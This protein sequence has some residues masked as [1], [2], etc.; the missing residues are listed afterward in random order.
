MQK[1]LQKIKNHITQKDLR[2]LRSLY[3]DVP[4][5]D[6]AHI[7]Q[8]LEKNHRLLFFRSLPRSTA[9]Q[10]FAH[11]EHDEENILITELTDTETR[12][13][14]H[15]LDPDDRT[16]FFE[17]LPGRVTQ[18]I[19]NLL[20]DENIAE[21]RMLLGYPEDTIGR[22]MTPDYI[23]VRPS[24]TIYQATEHVRQWGNKSETS[25][26]IYV[27]NTA[28]ELLGAVSLRNLVIANPDSTVEM[29]MKKP[30]IA[31]NANADQESAV[32]MM[33]KYDVGV[34]P[35]TD[36]N[37]ILVGIITVDDVLDIAE[38]ETTEDFHRSAAVG[39]FQENFLKTSIFFLYKKRIGW[40]VLLT[41]INI[42]S[43]AIILSY[44]A[45]LEQALVLVAFLP[46]LIDSAGNS[47]SQ[48]ATL[49]IRAMA[50]GDVTTD[51]W[52]RIIWREFRVALF[53]GATMG[54]AVWILG[55]F[56][57]GGL[58]ALV[59]ALTM[60]IVVM[61]GSIIGVSLPFILHKFKLDPA[62]ASSPLVTSM[63]DIFGVLIYLAIAKAILGI[64]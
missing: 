45:T 61:M 9:A 52:F 14:L 35:V 49:A 12:Q 2:G 25:D 42:I 28:W 15:D 1:L 43:G 10:V 55:V 31:I 29:I 40:L 59:I 46:L 41:F 19:L 23:A 36:D 20:D 27:T 17:E 6:L 50:T 32:H 47:G 3:K 22:L 21:I 56:R 37:N 13:L 57:A 51:D 8:N 34:L 39:A 64:G 44:E 53:L 7:F 48:S 26:V 5:A 24:W 54:G 63:A 33:Q 4:P 62:T 58:I 16:E 38:E 30:A 11:L 18:K 60:V